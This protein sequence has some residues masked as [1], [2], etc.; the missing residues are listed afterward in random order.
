MY[1]KKWYLF[2]IGEIFLENIISMDADINAMRESMP[3]RFR[4]RRGM[5]KPENHVLHINNHVEIYVYVSGNHQYI[6]ENSL[7]EL[8][9]GDI[10]I[11]NP[12]EVHKALPLD[13]KNLYERFY[14]LIDEHA[15]DAFFHNPLL[16]ILSR[17]SHF[18]NLIS[19]EEEK[20]EEVLRMLYGI[21]DCFRDGRNDQQRAFIFFLRILDEI[22]QGLK[23]EN[24]FI[25]RTAHTP[26]LLEKILSYVAEH[27][28]Q[29]QSTAEISSAIGV[30]PQYL[31]GYFSKHI[32]TPLKT[33]IQ[34][35]KIALAKEL[36]SKGADVTQT[37]YE[38][39]FNDCS[40]FIRI[41]K[42]YIGMTPLAYKQKT[43]I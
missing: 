39:G 38:C 3:I 27:T 8:R 34:A 1:H 16:Q 32:G 28:A 5:D 6:V 13:D 36:L 2:K 26:E 35:K 30:T 42:K 7:Y 23:T 15:L 33:Y 43:E 24:S 21:C 4:Y 22:N 9:R 31:S 11:I 37:C 18:G 19:L 14:F 40:Y 25:G 17:P 10:V 41:F 29:I 20:R 12:R